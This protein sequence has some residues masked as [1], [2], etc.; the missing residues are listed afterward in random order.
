MFNRYFYA[1]NLQHS[2]GAA[3]L[4]DL[5]QLF[6]VE[7]QKNFQSLRPPKKQQVQGSDGPSQLSNR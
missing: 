7:N 4:H 1:L 6:S 2:I 5:R 3:G